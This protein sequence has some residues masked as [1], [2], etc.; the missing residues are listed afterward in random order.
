VG[1]VLRSLCSDTNKISEYVSKLAVDLESD[2]SIIG[3]KQEEWFLDT[4][5]ASNDR[6]TKWRMILNQVIFSS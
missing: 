4:L 3:P 2:R 5:K 1:K 6:G